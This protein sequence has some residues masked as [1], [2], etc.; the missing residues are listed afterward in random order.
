MKDF[1]TSYFAACLV[2]S[3][4]DVQGLNTKINCLHESA[5]RITW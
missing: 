3:M 4:L 1:N 5:L 2:T